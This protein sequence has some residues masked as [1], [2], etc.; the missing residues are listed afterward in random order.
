MIKPKKV[1][2]GS[3]PLLNHPHSIE[4]E[5][6]RL[7]KNLNRELRKSCEKHLIPQFDGMVEGSQ[8]IKYDSDNWE[9]ELRQAMQRI[10][11]DMMRPI[12]FT[13]AQLDEIA[14]DV[15]GFNQKKW[16]ALIRKA[17]GVTPTKSDP[18]RYEQQ[19]KQWAEVNARLITDIPAKAMR[20]IYN[21]SITALQEGTTVKDLTNIVQ[22]RLG[23]SDSRAELIARDQVAKLNSD[24]VKERQVEND[25]T[26][27][28]WRTVQ[29]ERVR[30]SHRQ[31]DGNTYSWTA[32]GADTPCGLVPGDDYQCR[33]TAEPILPLYLEFQASLRNA[34]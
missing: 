18:E 13:Q 12:R 4:L 31:A 2:K 20:Q 29:D 24:L 32:N 21:E 5:Y 1:K 28:V 26:H 8:P 33:C 16:N 14:D 34:A 6:R 23:V 15:N 27:Y 19:M 10:G 7:L 30:D 11:R 3:L 17:Y 22:E 25:V 9:E